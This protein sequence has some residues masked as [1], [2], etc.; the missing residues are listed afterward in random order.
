LLPIR[1]VE[2]EP[3]SGAGSWSALI[4]DLVHYQNFGPIP[5][6][7]FNLHYAKSHDS[8][9]KTIVPSD[10]TKIAKARTRPCGAKELKM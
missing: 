9:A 7:G 3:L 8:R 6:R 1:R 4:P 5:E 10:G 2:R